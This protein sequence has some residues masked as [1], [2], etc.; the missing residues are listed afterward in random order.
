M[1][2][3][4]TRVCWLAPALGA[5]ALAGCITSPEEQEALREAE[6]AEQL[7]LQRMIEAGECSERPMTGQRTRTVYECGEEN[8]DMIDAARESMR[9]ISRQG[10]LCRGD[11]C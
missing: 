7:R 11:N 10:S 2:G 9:R 1:S 3:Y 5:I 6:Y 4:K 8:D